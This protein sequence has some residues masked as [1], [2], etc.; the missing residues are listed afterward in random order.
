MSG[1]HDDV[2][3][4]A[5]RN[6]PET[7]GFDAPRVFLGASDPGGVPGGGRPEPPPT[8]TGTTDAADQEDRVD[9]GGRR[10]L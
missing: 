2:P 6:P 3:E 10:H 1:H 9:P 8:E 7:G 5:P 4:W